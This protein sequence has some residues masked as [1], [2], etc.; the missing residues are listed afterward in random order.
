MG[1]HGM[2]KLQLGWLSK[3]SSCDREGSAPDRTNGL[4]S[5]PTPRDFQLRTFATTRHALA[6]QA[7][8]RSRGKVSGPPEYKLK[9]G[10]HP[11]TVIKHALE[12][13]EAYL[14]N[15]FKLSSQDGAVT[16][17]DEV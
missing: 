16:I 8:R 15:F 4:S 12:T 3:N 13:S 5:F 6:P 7:R 10:L 17:T 1:P 2:T 9:E 14:Q 11:V